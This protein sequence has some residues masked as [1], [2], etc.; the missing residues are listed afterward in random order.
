MSSSPTPPGPDVAIRAEQLGKCYHVYERPRDRLK[1]MLLGRSHRFYREF[2][3]LRDVTLEVRKGETVGIIGRNGSGKST[4]L[5]TIA[6]TLTPTTGD[7]HVDGRVSALLELGAGFN[8]EFTGRE[9]VFMNG[10]ILGISRAEMERRFDAIAAFADIG[11][12]IDQPTKTY[13]SGMQLRLA[14]SVAINVDPDVLIVDEA[15]AVGDAAFQFKCLERLEQLTRSGVTLLFVSHSMDMVKTFCSHVIYLEGGGVRAAG[16]ADEMAELYLCD[17]R[18]AQAQARESGSPVKWKQPLY[19]SGQSA[20]G[21]DDGRIV[22]AEFAS[23]GGQFATFGAGEEIVIEIGAEYTSTL[24]NPHLSV[25]LQD[26]RMVQIGGRHFALTGTASGH[27]IVRARVRC[28]FP[29]TFSGG[30]YF[31]TLRLED[32]TSEDL[33]FPVEKQVGLM[34]FEVFRDRA[35]L[36]GAVDLGMRVAELPVN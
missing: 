11:D 1:Q 2:W 31:I 24:R 4:L 35:E 29:A 12:F 34:S 32:R 18:A 26:R 8:P 3:A 19:A 28:S 7:I 23:G 10:A 14:F 16:P 36:L 9:N 33:F 13:S 27:G 6:G 5:Q 20:F 25:V 15:L 22:Q 30:R 17:V 21:T